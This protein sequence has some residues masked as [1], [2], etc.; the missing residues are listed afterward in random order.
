MREERVATSFR[1]R[2]GTMEGLR[3][4]AEAI[5]ASQAEVIERLV[6]HACRDRGI[7]L[8]DD[9]P[10][11]CLEPLQPQVRADEAEQH[12]A[13]GRHTARVEM[14]LEGLYYNV[15]EPN[16][17]LLERRLDARG[18]EAIAKVAEVVGAIQAHDTAR[19]GPAQ[20]PGQLPLLPDGAD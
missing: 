18:R 14:A 20:V 9:L 11:P 15:I 4:L 16:A 13:A 3:Q 6:R 12:R 2:P 1:F 17:R 7:V 8:P 19:Q 5:D 10:P